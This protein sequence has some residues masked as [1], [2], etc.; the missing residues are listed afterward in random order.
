[1]ELTERTLM[2]EDLAS[3]PLFRSLDGDALA[4]L[5]E[6]FVELRVDPNEM[7]FEEGD[8]AEFFF[9]IDQGTLA[10]FRDAVGEPVHLLTRLGRHDFFGELGLFGSGHYRASVRAT[11]DVRLW[12]IE[13]APFLAFVEKHPAVQLQL[14]TTAALRQ[15]HQVAST[16]ELGRRRE[17]RIRC[18]Q[19]VTLELEDGQRL[20]LGLENLSL[21]GICLADA[22]EAWKEGM[23]L[24]FGLQVREGLLPLHGLVRWRS[25]DTVGI[26]FEK[27]SPKHD[28]LLQMAIRL[29]MESGH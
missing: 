26:G 27:R 6:A 28:P 21:G 2:G 19:E 7:I 20:R 18:K 8:P 25:G 22:P 12:R 10:V 3:L 11:E 16:L 15:G 9:V 5:A 1:M 23:E 14:Q 13:R 4:R 24:S 17:V 29:I